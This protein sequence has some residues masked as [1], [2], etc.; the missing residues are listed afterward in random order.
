MVDNSFAADCLRR[1]SGSRP[2]ARQSRANQIQ[3]FVV[4][5][6]LLKKSCRSQ[7]QS[8]LFVELRI[9][10]GQHDHR[11]ARQ[12]IAILQPLQDHEA[13]ARGQA[14][15]KN[16]Q[17]GAFLLGHGHGGVAIR[18]LHGVVVVGLQA[19][20]QRPAQVGVV[21]DDQYFLVFHLS[22]LHTVLL[23]KVQC[24]LVSVCVL[25]IWFLYNGSM[26]VS[27]IRL[28]TSCTCSVSDLPS[29]AEGSATALAETF[30]T[31][32]ALKPR[33]ASSCSRMRCIM[34]SA[35]SRSVEA[36]TKKV[37][38]I[39]AFPMTGSTRSLSR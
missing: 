4:I 15:V 28:A 30:R 18:S 31:A 9:A 29:P 3:Q 25:G 13:I 5:R 16:D 8:F 14:E 34:I 19:Y 7:R 36:A 24:S 23:F 26:A 33:P 37:W 21:I 35:L 38:L 17:V 11:N 1:Q 27:V 39:P 12:G 6:G 10:C 20:S 32:A 2:F 22:L